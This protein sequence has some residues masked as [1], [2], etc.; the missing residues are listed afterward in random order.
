VFQQL[1]LNY[2]TVR[3]YDD[4]FARIARR[5]VVARLASDGLERRDALYRCVS[6]HP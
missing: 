6:D 4:M 5:F 3:S 2:I 1:L